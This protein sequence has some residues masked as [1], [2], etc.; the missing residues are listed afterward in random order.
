MSAKVAF[1]EYRKNKVCPPRCENSGHRKNCNWLKANKLGKTKYSVVKA[2]QKCPYSE[3][4]RFARLY[5]CPSKF[6]RD[7]KKI[8]RDSYKMWRQYP[9][10]PQLPTKILSSSKN[11][12]QTTRKTKKDRSQPKVKLH[13]LFGQTI[14]N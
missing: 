8:L 12:L 9:L 2:I 7:I 3:S 6:E 13:N 5:T 10:F 1:D 11:K 4:P 14:N